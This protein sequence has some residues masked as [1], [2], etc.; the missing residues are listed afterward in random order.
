MKL[1][2]AQSISDTEAE[3]PGRRFAVWVQGC[4]LRCDGCCNPELFA[5]RGGELVDA[6]QLADEVL[7]VPGI[8]GLTVLGG[9]PFEQAP[10][11]AELC[12]RVRGGG[13]SV[14]IFSGYRLGELRARAAAEPGV[15]ELL[16][17]VDVLV[18]GRYE[19]HF[20]ERRRRWV[21]SSN[22]VVHFLSGRYR[23]DDPRFAASNSVELRL[24]GGALTVHGWPAAA[25]EVLR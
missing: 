19:R 22:Q 8:E 4:S 5:P 6:G 23:A 14:M 1:R 17:C 24:G 15:A 21:G 11:V 9:E 12:G 16:A 7:A 3:G 25:D 20:P 10:A 13:R 2:V 18:D